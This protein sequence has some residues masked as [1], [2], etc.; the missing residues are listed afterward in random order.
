MTPLVDQT[1]AP[2]L[3]PATGQ[4]LVAAPMLAH[5]QVFQPSVQI[6]GAD[7]AVYAVQVA[8]AMVVAPPN[9]VQGV[10]QIIVQQPQVNKDLSLV[11]T[12]HVN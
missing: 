9:Q 10:Q 12:D 3:D 6:A 2:M 1:G 7:G 11:N 5:G 8:P 4:Q